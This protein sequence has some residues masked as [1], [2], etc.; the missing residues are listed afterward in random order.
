MRLT[1]A[2]ILPNVADAMNLATAATGDLFSQTEK[3]LHFRLSGYAQIPPPAIL[4]SDI[5]CGSALATE[6]DTYRRRIQALLHFYDCISQHWWDRLFPYKDTL[7]RR[8]SK[9]ADELR[10]EQSRLAVRINRC[11]TRSIIPA[12]AAISLM[13]AHAT[14]KLL[15]AT[16]LSP[17]V[18]EYMHPSIPSAM[19][20]INA[21]LNK[22][23]SLARKLSD[24]ER[25]KQRLILSTLKWIN[26]D[27]R[28]FSL[29]AHRLSLLCRHVEP[30]LIEYYSAVQA[31]LTH[32]YRPRILP[33]NTLSR[34][35]L[36]SARTEPITAARMTSTNQQILC[37]IKQANPKA[38]VSTFGFPL[39]SDLDE[40]D[41]DSPDY[42]GGLKGFNT[43]RNRL[44]ESPTSNQV[45]S[46][47][48]MVLNPFSID[49]TRLDWLSYQM[50]QREF[51]L[52]VLDMEE[53]E[54]AQHSGYVS[55]TYFIK[56]S[57]EKQTSS[58]PI[59]SPI[60]LD[61]EDIH[62]KTSGEFLELIPEP[63]FT[64]VHSAERQTVPPL[65]TV[66]KSS[67]G[68]LVPLTPKSST[69][70]IVAPN[71]RESIQTPLEDG[72]LRPRYKV[73][74]ESVSSESQKEVLPSPQGERVN[75]SSNSSDDD[76]DVRSSN[77]RSQLHTRT[78]GKGERPKEK[79][80]ARKPVSS[81]G[82]AF[83]RRR[84]KASVHWHPVHEIFDDQQAS[85]SV[86]AKTDADPD[87]LT[88]I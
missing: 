52:H 36:S 56:S 82:S 84:P 75:R 49:T 19:D 44:S 40:N 58:A 34:Q 72:L 79:A 11:N 80:Y 23:C 73:F 63:S 66:S 16:V 37:A 59:I 15:P 83:R 10:A 8:P 62:P 13:E 43:V 14:V 30:T 12:A 64:R 78:D 81:L 60:P 55:P 9:S 38:N 71:R 68:R 35:L 6:I 61:S 76:Y 7:T 48:S 70:L 39:Q 45:T 24:I 27:G 17:V 88:R 47:P 18:N 69:H 26:S 32:Y 28:D 46:L 3:E 20:N 25:L 2:H 77:G 51:N 42:S 4:C 5:K 67:D 53:P 57:I 1:K 65:R 85:I 31:L 54:D 41:A 87:F 86:S 50:N 74:M 29:R 21:L 33:R 22:A